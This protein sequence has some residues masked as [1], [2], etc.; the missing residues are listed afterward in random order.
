MQTPELFLLATVVITVAVSLYVGIIYRTSKLALAFI[1]LISSFAFWAIMQL[2]LFYSS[3][4]A[5]VIW[6]RRITYLCG[7][8]LAWA[9]FYFS[10]VFVYPTLGWF[11]VLRRILIIASIF[12]IYLILSSNITITRS[13]MPST[14]KLGYLELSRFIFFVITFYSIV[15]SSLYTFY[16]KYIA[17]TGE[18]RFVIKCVAFSAAVPFFFGS[19]F[20]V[21]LPYFGFPE[22]Q[23]Y[24]PSFT[25]FFSLTVFYLMF[26]RSRFN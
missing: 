14:G 15:I 19:V 20:N 11:K 7:F 6:L 12:S 4:P 21:Y 23:M 10:L 24:G 1:L 2:L 26:I 5:E 3:D 17:S 8:P 16:K 22:Y 18:N 25:L 9:F 13:L